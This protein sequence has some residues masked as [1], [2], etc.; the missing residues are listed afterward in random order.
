[1]TNDKR[2]VIDFRHLNMYIAKNNLACPLL[3]DTSA[4]LGSSKCE[5]MSV[6]D[7]KDAFHPPKTDRKLKEIM[8]N[9]SLFLLCKAVHSHV[10][11]CYLFLY[12]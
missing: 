9:S 4:L 7:L 1:M 3:N 12:M 11:N 8:W 5:Y 10:H 2:V 6:L